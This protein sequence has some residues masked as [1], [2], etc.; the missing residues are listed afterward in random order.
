MLSREPLQLLL[1][2]GAQAASL[3]VSAACRDHASSGATVL[4]MCAKMLPASCRQ[5]RK[6]S[7]PALPRKES[8]GSKPQ[9]IARGTSPLLANFR[10]C[11]IEKA[12]PNTKLRSPGNA[13]T[14]RSN[15]KNIRATTPG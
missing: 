10:L 8:V 6:H 7:G 15:I 9:D 4:M 14:H 2:W 13:A 5:P 1:V 12:C 11:P 3:W